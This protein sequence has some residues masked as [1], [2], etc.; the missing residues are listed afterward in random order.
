MVLPWGRGPIAWW[1][2]KGT[3]FIR[4]K[5]PKPLTPRLASLGLSVNLG[6]HG[7]P[8]STRSEARRL[9]Y[10]MEG[11]SERQDVGNP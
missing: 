10:C 1:V 4:Q 3:T 7:K 5:D 8:L 2:P 9:E 11:Q 6:C